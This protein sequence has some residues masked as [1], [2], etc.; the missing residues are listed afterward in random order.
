MPPTLI[1]ISGGSGSGKSTLAEA[2]YAHLGPERA[3][4][5]REDAYYWP[6]SHY[7]PTVA[8]HHID[9]DTPESKDVAHL[10]RDL[11]ALKAEEPVEQPVYDFERHDR[12]SG[13]THRLEPRPV[14][15]LEGIHVLSVPEV[16]ALVDLAV[17]VDTPDDLR[18]VRRIRRDVVQRGRDV[19]GVLA[20]YV[21]TVRVAH[22]RHTH[23][24]KF[25]ADLVLADDGLP[26]YGGVGPPPHAVAR[27][28]APVL[29][30]LSRLGGG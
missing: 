14:L 16:R 24:A 3:V 30:R 11:A 22:Y 8:P 4:V 20:Q 2:L 19:E 13:R 12:E 26:A 27:M 29:E 17:Y 21:G 6:R 10:A 1:A 5:I 15:L 7:A 25:H 18:L 9:Y 28:M 23:P